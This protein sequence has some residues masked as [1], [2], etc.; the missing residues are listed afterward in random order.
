MFEYSCSVLVYGGLW[1]CLVNF[2]WVGGR[3]RKFLFE[4]FGLCEFVCY[5]RGMRRKN[6]VLL[7]FWFVLCLWGWIFDGLYVV[8][9]CWRRFC[10]CWLAVGKGVIGLNCCCGG[11]RFWCLLYLCFVGIW[12]LFYGVGCIFVGYIID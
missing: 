11:G 8:N 9:Y 1:L 2:L 5:R 12:G 7:L 10:V 6:I 3:S 4:V